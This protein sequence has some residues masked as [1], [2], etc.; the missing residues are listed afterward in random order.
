MFLA[1]SIDALQTT[2]MHTHGGM[3]W[4]PV[5]VPK[6][7]IKYFSV[8]G[9]QGCGPRPSCLCWLP[10]KDA[11]TFADVAFTEWANKWPEKYKGV[12]V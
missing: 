11:V 7:R 9:E 2:Q 4:F 3:L 5:L 8:N 6:R 1:F 10:P 12:V